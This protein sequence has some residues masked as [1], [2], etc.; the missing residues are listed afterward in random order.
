MYLLYASGGYVFPRLY[1]ELCR[2]YKNDDACKRLGA[3]RREDTNCFVPVTD[4]IIILKAKRQLPL[5]SLVVQ[6]VVCVLR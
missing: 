2:R 1:S 6:L 5:L 4:V 3:C